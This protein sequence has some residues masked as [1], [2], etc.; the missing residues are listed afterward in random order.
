MRG[1]TFRRSS[2]GGH[3]VR[4]SSSRVY[5]APH[6]RGPAPAP[7]Q[8]NTPRLLVTI[9]N[10]DVEEPPEAAARAQEPVVDQLPSDIHGEGDHARQRE[11]S[12]SSVSTNQLTPA[13]ARLFSSAPNRCSVVDDV[14]ELLDVH[15]QGIELNNF[16]DVFEA[17][18]HRPLDSHWT[19]VDNLRQMLESMDDLVECEERGSEVIVTK[20]LGNECFQGNTLQFLSLIHI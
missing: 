13:V 1:R 5:Q 14:S 11:P 19:D 20:K 7:Y 8:S 16:C 3:E 6:R 18:F 2:V 9:S 10:D 12:A 17:C 15:P 4:D